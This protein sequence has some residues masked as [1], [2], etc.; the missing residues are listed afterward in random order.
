MYLGVKRVLPSSSFFS[1]YCISLG[2]CPS[3]GGLVSELSFKSLL[4]PSSLCVS[5]YTPQKEAGPPRHKVFMCPPILYLAMPI[6]ATTIV[7]S[8]FLQ[9]FLSSG[10]PVCHF[11][12]ANSFSSSL[13]SISLRSVP[14]Y[15]PKEIASLFCRCPEAL[16]VVLSAVNK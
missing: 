11:L 3:A 5:W 9:T 8:V 6:H 10:C 1:K 15:R 14:R 13:L 16:P 4:F 2:Q 7:S 12:W